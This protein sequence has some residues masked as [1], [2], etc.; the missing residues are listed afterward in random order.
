MGKPVLLS[1]FS[2]LQVEG[3]LQDICNRSDFSVLGLETG[4]GVLLAISCCSLFMGLLILAVLTTVLL[5]YLLG[6]VVDPQ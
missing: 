6:L 5:P 1:W 3:I 4:D 2:Q